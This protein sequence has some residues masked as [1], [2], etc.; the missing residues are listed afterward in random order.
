MWKGWN[1]KYQ[2]SGKSLCTLYP[3]HGYLHLLVAIGARGVN[4]GELLMPLCTEYIQNLWGQSDFHG[5]RYL[6]IE[7][8]NEN[9][10]AENPDRVVF[11]M[12]KMGINLPGYLELNFEDT[13]DG[14]TITEQIRIGFSSVGIALDPFIK[15]VYSKRF[16]KEMD[17]HHKREWISLAECFK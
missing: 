5:S 16:F 8:R 11:Q 3:K 17:T 6:G 9:V 10:I 4:E 1:I 15:I 2:K 12:Q 14:L 13:P 7:L